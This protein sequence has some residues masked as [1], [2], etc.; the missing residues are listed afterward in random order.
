MDNSGMEV[1]AAQSGS[2]S[3]GDAVSG[4]RQE[5][6]EEEEDED[7]DLYYI[8]ER[9]PSLDLGPDPMDTSHWHFV[10]QFSA[11]ALSYCSMTS[12]EDSMQ[13]CSM[14]VEDRTSSD[15]C[16][17]VQLDRADS[18]SSCYSWDSDDCEKRTLKVKNKEEMALDPSDDT[19]ELMEDPKISHPSLTVAFTFKALSDTLMKLS[20]ADFKTFKT[21]LWKRYPQS[22]PAPQLDLVDLVDRLLECYSLEVSIKITETLLQEI[23]LRK[24]VDYLQ[25]LRIRNEVRYDVSETLKNKYAVHEVSSV[26]GET[27]L[28]QDI[29][30]DLYMTST[31]EN[32]PNIEHE[33][34]TIEKLDT[35]YDAGTR[36][37]TSDIFNT[38]ILEESNIKL[39]LVS[40]VAALARERRRFRAP[41]RSPDEELG[42][43]MELGKLAFNM[44]EKGQFK[45]TKVGWKEQ[46]RISDDE[47]VNL[48]GLCTQF[49]TKPFVLIQERV[50]SFLHPTVQEYLAALYVFLSFKNQGTNVLR[51]V[52]GKLIELYKCALDRSLACEDGKLD[53]FLRFLFGMMSQINRELLQPF[54]S[55]SVE[56]PP[57]V[58]ED[59]A[60]LIR[61]KIEENQYP[62]RTE[63]LRRCLE[64]LGV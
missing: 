20:K 30:T 9:R 11:P 59:A 4:R 29:Y 58:T 61:K 43:L 52:N 54:C 53:I 64:E 56:W 21:T 14:D 33:V 31:S 3:I 25:T 34:V 19:P 18:F 45:I 63:N 55:S 1:V 24:L 15:T 32:G 37:S 7:E 47:A 28:F 62:A 8:P 50:F 35:N 60:A 22:F 26:P 6:P 5:V 57:A 2:S 17:R 38:K 40:G 27:R 16:T 42:F 23:G 49:I 48:S 36:L 12:S 41:D 46:V 51:K 44:L 13:Q 39:I 10:R